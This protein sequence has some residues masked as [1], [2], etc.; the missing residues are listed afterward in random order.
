[1]S[2]WTAFGQ[3]EKPSEGDIAEYQLFHTAGFRG[4]LKCFETIHWCQPK[5][6]YLNVGGKCSGKNSSPK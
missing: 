1:M 6:S 3:R 4:R 2:L 5:A